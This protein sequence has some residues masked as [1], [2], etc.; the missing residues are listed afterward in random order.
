MSAPALTEVTIALTA[1]EG[2]A[3]ERASDALKWIGAD[4]FPWAFAR[5]DEI[6]ACADGLRDSLDDYAAL[7]TGR[8]H[9][10]SLFCDL[11]AGHPDGAIGDALDRVTADIRDWTRELE[12]LA[13][14][15]ETAFRAREEGRAA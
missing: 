8:T 13:R 11:A 3:I 2:E 5:S 7:T 6:K 10:A 14:A 12:A 1:A 15:A 4:T 9:P